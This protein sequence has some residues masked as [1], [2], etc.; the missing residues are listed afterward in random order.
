[1]DSQG[2]YSRTQTLKPDTPAWQ[3]GHSDFLGT[4]TIENSDR[5]SDEFDINF[6]LLKIAYK[7]YYRELNIDT[8][9]YSWNL[10]NQSR[11][12]VTKA[13]RRARTQEVK[14]KD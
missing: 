9:I 4:D 5:V 10:Y 2:I 14:P 8:I 6:E 7:F 3:I 11:Q 13:I 12:L 1:V